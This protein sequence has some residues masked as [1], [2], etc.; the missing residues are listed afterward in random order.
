MRV[1]SASFLV[2]ALM[3]T[4]A[5]PA[6]SQDGQD[7]GAGLTL[8]FTQD[9]QTGFGNATGGGQ[10]SAGG[11]EINQVW[12][13]YEV[14]SSLLRL[15]ITGNLEG[16]FNKLFLF[17]DGVAGGENVLDASN[18]DGGFNEIQNLAGLTF[19]DG[20]TADHGLRIEVG[21]GFYGVNQ[22]DL[23][24]N[25]AST[26]VS[27]GGPGDLPLTRVGTA[28]VFL[29]WDN[30]N[31]LGVDDASAA[32]A[33]TATTGWE[34]EIDLESLLGAAPTQDIGVTGFVTSPDAT[35]VSNQ[36]IGGVGGADNLGAGGGINFNSIAGSQFVTIGVT[37]IPEP[38]S[39]VVL[40]AIG[41]IGFVTRRRRRVSG[42]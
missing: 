1:S 13:D 25:T 23:I 19:D 15:S 42:L 17:I 28:G 29:G 4:T 33:A 40:M 20:F 31:V 2:I 3:A 21:D 30:S 32:N 24:G 9:T 26:V 27:G 35:F 11:S 6:F 7:L 18:L 34:F 39:A 8:R 41:S 16:N 36:V 22:F 5:R 38:G 12:G 10:N 37:A 14:G